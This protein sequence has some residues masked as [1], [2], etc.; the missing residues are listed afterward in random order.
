VDEITIFNPVLNPMINI[1]ER[2]DKSLERL[3]SQL[4]L[5][6]D[7]SGSFEKAVEN[8]LFFCGIFPA[9]FIKD[10]KQSGRLDIR[11]VDILA[12]NPQEENL[13]VVECTTGPVEIDKLAK[14]LS[15]TQSM[16]DM[17]YIANPVLFTTTSR[18]TL[19]DEVS[20]KA[21]NDKISIITKE[22]IETLLSMAERNAHPNEVSEF[23]FQC[24][25]N[26]QIPSY[27]RIR[28]MR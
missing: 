1:Y 8:L 12:L 19:A 14:L 9:P 6:G 24:I 25:P 2:F 28:D 18:K 15:R 7:N 23:I 21:Q 10:I 11:G 4:S 16:I 13:F 3:K 22:D 20:K 5:I 27:F 17:G 26:F